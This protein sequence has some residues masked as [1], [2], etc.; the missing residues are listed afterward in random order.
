MLL[1]VVNAPKWSA[2]TGWGVTCM[3][4]GVDLR[5]VGGHLALQERASAIETLAMRFLTHI[6]AETCVVA[7]P[8]INNW[9]QHDGSMQVAQFP[10]CALEEVSIA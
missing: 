2:A 5:Y 4:T 6:C 7:C 9:Y 8:R 1:P 3:L 10:T